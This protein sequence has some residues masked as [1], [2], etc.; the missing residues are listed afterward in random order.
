M[1]TRAIVFAALAGAIGATA[2]DVEAASSRIALSGGPLA[3]SERNSL[4][5][6]EFA[7]AAAPARPLQPGEM[8]VLGP[9]AGPLYAPVPAPVLAPVQSTAP[10]PPAVDTITVTAPESVPPE[11]VPVVARSPARTWESYRSG[12]VVRIDLR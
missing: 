11:S 2:A 10:I 12:N 6:L 5:P 4:A 1:K 3:S 9:I 8:L 7:R